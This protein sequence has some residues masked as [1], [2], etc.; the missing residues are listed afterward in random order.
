MN[1]LR[2]LL[3]ISFS[4]ALFVGNTIGLDVFEHFCSVDK[5]ASYSY[6][7]PG[8]DHCF[9]AHEPHNDEGCCVKESTDNG[10]CEDDIIHIYL[11]FDYSNEYAAFDTDVFLDGIPT[12]EFE[13]YKENVIN[14][15]I[16]FA[17]QPNPPP[18]EPTQRRSLH[19][20]FIV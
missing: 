10:C 14:Q 1:Q 20:V 16:A 19:Q 17:L 7:I 4:I 3:I 6:I 5:T 13:L 2:S 11:D 18:L 12:I 15:K 9:D 8:D